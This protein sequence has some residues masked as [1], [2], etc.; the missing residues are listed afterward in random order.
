MRRT[1]HLA[2]LLLACSDPVTGP[3]DGGGDAGRT[4]GGVETDAR[5][6]EPD[7]AQTD[8][9]AAACDEDRAVR[10]GAC[11]PCAGGAT[12]DAGDEPHGPDTYCDDACSAALGVDCEAFADAY[13]KAARPGTGDAFGDVVALDGNTLAVAATQEASAS[14]GVD[15]DA[16][17]DS[18]PAAG[19][20]YV[21]DRVGDGWVQTGYLKASNTDEDDHFGSALA[22]QGDTLV[23]GAPRESSAATGVGGDDRDNSASWAGAAYVFTRSGGRWSQAAYLKPSHTDESDRFGVAVAL[24]GDTIAIGAEGEGLNGTGVNVPLGSETEP[25]S[26]AVFVFAHAGGP[27]SQTAHIKPFNT[28]DFAYFGDALVLDGD[29]LAVTAYGR[30]QEAFIFERRAGEWSQTA[31][32]QVASTDAEDQFGW[33][34]ALSGDTVVVGAPRESGAGTGVDGDEEDDSLEEAGA[35]YVFTLDGGVWSQVA[36]LKASNTGAG[37]LF[38]H[39][40]AIDGDLIA[41]AAHLEDSAADGVDWGQSDDSAPGAG[42]VY[43]FERRGAAWSALAY[44]KAPNSDSLDRFGTGLAL[45]G[46]FLAVGAHGDDAAS[47]ADPRDN[48]VEDSGAAYV[49]RVRP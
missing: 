22:L 35:A 21:F 45:S 37:D 27:R 49:F 15:G 12:N 18:A 41:V 13:V 4:D 20:V 38:G 32:L 3:A 7:A 39:R 28:N 23:V 33:S 19:A 9:G 34:I 8:G 47:S 5:V 30:D 26:G 44:V 42:A 24:D 2:S 25:Y 40:V 43:L 36:Y 31:H 17:D 1:L 14:T 16:A 29:R 11:V 46:D 6:V 48:T 10:G